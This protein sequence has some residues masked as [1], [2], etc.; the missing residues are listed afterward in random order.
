MENKRIVLGHDGDGLKEKTG[1]KMKYR[2]LIFAVTFFILGLA[3]PSFAQVEEYKGNRINRYENIHSGNKV[4]TIFYNYGLV[5][6]IGE[7]SGEWP[8][9][10]GNEY[11]GDVSPL[12]AV[13]FVHPNGDT[14]HSVITSDGPRRNTDGEGNNHWTFEPLPGFAALPNPGEIGQVAMNHLKETWPNF[15][16]DKMFTDLN[17]RLWRR[18]DFD[19]GWSGKWN[20]YFG[21][22]VTNADQE[23]YFQMD[24]H[25]DQEWRIR[26]L[27]STVLGPDSTYIDSVDENGDRVYVTFHPDISDTSRQG[28]G[29]RVAVRGFQWSHFLAEDCI[30]WHLEITNIGTTPY[31]KVAFGMVV[32][33]LSGGRQDSE[34]DLAFFDP[35]EDI[36]YSFDSDDIGSPGWEPVRAGQINVGW[37]GYAFLES[38]GNSYDGIDND[39]D[40]PNPSPE[41]T[42]A[43]LT[44]WSVDS[45]GTGL[46][47]NPGDKLIIIDYDTYK[48]TRVTMPES[49]VYIWDFR[50]EEREVRADQTYFEIKYNGIDDNYNGL[51]DEMIVVEVGGK[52]LDH[53]GKKYVDYFAASEDDEGYLESPDPMIDE[54]RD[55]GI[56]NDGDWNPLAHDVG[57]DGVPGTGDFGEGDGL[58]TDGE[59]N[60]DKTD[61]NE[62]D[63]I[64]LT[65]FEYFSPPGAVRMNNDDRLWTTMLPGHIDVVSLEP[66]DGDFVFGSSYF[67]LPPGKTERFSIACFFGEDS[68][69]IFKNKETVQ[70]VYDAN[71]NFARP[72]AKP[73]VRVVPGDGR[74][75]LYW[76]DIAEES[77]D[78]SQPVGKQYDFEGYKIYRATDPGFL[79]NFIITD[80][81][82]RK[83][84]HKP[85]AQFDLDDGLSGFFPNTIFGAA[86]YL[87]EDTGLQ[88]VWT[89]TTV[90][91][92]QR[93]FYAVTSYDFGNDSLDFFPAETSKYIFLDEGG[94]ITTDVNTI[95]VV[96]G[97]TGAGYEPPFLGAIERVSGQS[98]SMAYAEVIDPAQVRNNA[99]YIIKFGDVNESNEA[100]SYSIYNVIA[101][102]DTVPA[103]DAQ[104][105]SMLNMDL[106]VA[107]DEVR[108]MS[109]FNSYFD[110]L[111]G[112]YAGSY[113]TRRYYRTVETGLFDG[114]RLFLVKPNRPG[115]LIHEASGWYTTTEER[116]DSLLQY[117]FSVLNLPQADLVGTPWYADYQIVFHDEVIDSSDAW[118][119][120]ETLTL[121]ARGKNF[122]LRNLTQGYEPIVVFNDPGTIT[123]PEDSCDGFVSGNSA[124]IIFE[125]IMVDDQLDTIATWQCTFRNL[126]AS[127]M[128]YNPVGGDTLTIRMFKSPNDE[129]MFRFTS[130]S[131]RIN[132]E[133]VDLNRIR[134]YPNPYLG[135]STQEPA[136]PYSSGRG[137]RRI[138]FI[139]L[140][141]QCTIRI[142]NIRGEL[143]DTIRHESNSGDNIGDGIANWDLRT[144]DGLDVAYG[145][146]I[147]HIRSEYGEHVGKFALIK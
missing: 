43:D 99:E 6:N 129:D 78:Q 74:V 101:P 141:N 79:E 65:S 96:P 22:D 48:R 61:I 27:K 128:V 2:P 134:V 81:L 105:R 92:G 62:S 38:P 143:V 10:T 100:E 33:T 21:K 75:T 13:E 60:F 39:G 107:G 69:D 40:S 66:E 37:C 146:Y 132:P 136:N 59:P 44:N 84:F 130:E 17:D 113:E 77:F 23:S 28:C 145:V 123:N 42:V 26:A 67:P 135:A 7:I 121:P 102:G 72:P 58:P 20:G 29:I 56:D 18:D 35:A 140:P 19:P 119:F 14:L 95:W 63:Q 41:L 97:V 90:E 80:G 49:G 91:N 16:P 120:S 138:T 144:K 109:L 94:N 115:D 32:G 106:T 112:L 57:F 127:G 76:D 117:V 114:I 126:T 24:D 5:G 83:V 133:M 104:N 86:F 142:Y 98:N 25:A 103:R 1:R 47:Y 122:T 12:V 108:V 85:I 88:H 110:S 125:E 53:V 11:I 52:R 71:Y 9:G 147:Y 82:G 93:Y 54:A 34:D 116:S 111:Y 139:H 55:D 31:D 70:Q 45:I 4:R 124:I 137:E 8:L 3:L 36:C 15:W 87:G 46:V 68:T 118:T 64:G 89:D 50:G 30:I 73:T 51:L 131:A